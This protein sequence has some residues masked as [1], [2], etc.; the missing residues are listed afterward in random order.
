MRV[1]HGL[2]KCNLHLNGLG[3]HTQPYDPHL[4]GFRVMLVDD[5]RVVIAINNCTGDVDGN[6]LKRF[7]GCK[8]VDK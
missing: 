6:A 7:I 2:E 8:G 1:N 3:Q 5:F 4:L